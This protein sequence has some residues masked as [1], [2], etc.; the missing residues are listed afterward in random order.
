MRQRKF[1]N[2]DLDERVVYTDLKSEIQKLGL[3]QQKCAE[4]L[5][6][7]RGGL[8]NRINS[9]NKTLHW[10]ILGLSK[11]L[12]EESEYEEQSI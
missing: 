10:A 7:T 4:L 9:D 5:G 1:Y 8:L 12:E 2:K 6:V 3:T 11:Y